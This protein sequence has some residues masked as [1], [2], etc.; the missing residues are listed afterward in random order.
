MDAS[1]F[2]YLDVGNFWMK[3]WNQQYVGDRQGD[4]S[5]EWPGG[6]GVTYV[7]IGNLWFGCIKDGRIHVSGDFPYL[8]N[9]WVP[10]GVT[11]TELLASDK[12]NWSQRPSKV[13]TT[14]DL[15]TYAICDDSDAQE[16]GPVDLLC[17]V[18]GICWSAPGHDDWVVLEC[19]IESTGATKLEDCY[20]S[21]AYDLDIGGSLDYIDDLVGYDGNDNY[22]IDTNPTKPGEDWRSGPDGIPDENDAVNF[23]SSKAS[24]PLDMNDEGWKRMMAYMYDEGGEARDTPGYCGLRVM[25]WMAEPA[26]DNLIEVSSQHSWDIMNDPDTDAYKYGYM[27]D[28]GTFE[29][30]NT[31][32]DWRID[33]CFGPFEMEKDDVV[34]WWTGI[35]MGGDLN[36][37]RKN[38]DALYA[39][40][41]GPDG[42]PDTLDDW[43]VVAPPASP[44]L[45]AV[46]GDN[47]VTLRWNPNYAAG[48]NTETD[49]D[50]RSGIRDFDGYVVFRSNVGFDSGWEAIL[51]V[52]KKTTSDKASVVPWGWRTKRGTSQWI[53]QGGATYLH[54][55]IPT[56]PTGEHPTDPDLTDTPAVAYERVPRSFPA[57]TR[58]GPT[59]RLRRVGSYYEFVDG[60]DG[61]GT[62][63]GVLNNGTRYYY[64]VVAYDFGTRKIIKKWNNNTKTFEDWMSEADAAT[65]GGKNV[66]GLSVIPLPTTANALDRIRVVPNPYVG[67]ADWEEWTGSGARL[68]RLYF[69]NLP[70][71]CTIRIYTIAGDL[72]RTLEHHDV[73]YGA[74]PWDLTGEA[75]V[76]VASGIYVYHVDAPD[77]GEKIGKFAVL[78]GA[79]S[80]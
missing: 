1:A 19:W 20:I 42:L 80:Q 23:T 33:P 69:M 9:E 50:P 16:N 34:H 73:A 60:V 56:G 29:E 35:V 3:I 49:P 45:I 8:A 51:W 37:L 65:Q 6:S 2:D 59:V 57:P 17:E 22:D 38:A 10:I 61:A 74:E 72:V 18:H 28:V 75:G 68:D 70:P 11:E 54:E 30:I 25:G 48:K 24:K 62:S 43:Q 32:Y 58:Q 40:F 4:K 53:S 55:R 27:I 66:N 78:I 71:K 14:G 36:G 67:S 52:D 44:R 12:A 31:A 26:E 13:N 64:A 77:Y 76:L 63:T 39:D 79:Q 47:T 15:D 21:L 41:L 46:R 7:Y 5:G